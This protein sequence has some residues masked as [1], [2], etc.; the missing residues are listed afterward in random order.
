MQSQTAAIS[1]RTRH[2]RQ[3]RTLRRRQRA[4]RPASLTPQ[5]ESPVHHPSYRQKNNSCSPMEV[6]VQ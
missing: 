5:N 1:T 4:V 6:L 3:T 2:N